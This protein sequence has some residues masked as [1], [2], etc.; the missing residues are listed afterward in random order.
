M[1]LHRISPVQRT[2]SISNRVSDP[3]DDNFPRLNG[4]RSRLS[5]NIPADCGIGIAQKW[6]CTFSVLLP[7]HLQRDC[8]FLEKRGSHGNVGSWLSRLDKA[9]LKA[10]ISE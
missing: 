4:M 9:G 3:K 1:N 7:D 10:P 5:A 2:C 6:D 8:K